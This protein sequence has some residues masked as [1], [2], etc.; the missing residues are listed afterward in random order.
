MTMPY[1]GST[2]RVFLILASLWKM[3]RNKLHEYYS[4]F[5]KIMR[6]NL[7]WI[8]EFY[9]KSSKLHLPN[10][11]FKYS[12]RLE[13]KN[14]IDILA[15]HIQNLKEYKGFYF[16]D[17]FMS[18][19]LHIQELRLHSKHIQ[20]FGSYLDIFKSFKVIY[21]GLKFE[22]EKDSESTT[23]LD[24]VIIKIQSDSF[25]FEGL[26]PEFKNNFTSKNQS[27]NK[28]WELIHEDLLPSDFNKNSINQDL[29]LVDFK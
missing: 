27:N 25:H 21:E 7:K 23:L 20:H 6:R 17:Y 3:S 12:I 28:T 2:D 4:E 14:Q 18:Q 13:S 5:T 1:Y 16:E 8:D 9:S 22:F 19:H 10:D 26:H 24:V 15:Q 11:I 29:K